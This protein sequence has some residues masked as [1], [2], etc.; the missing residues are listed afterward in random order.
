MRS[1][2]DNLKLIVT[3]SLRPL[4]AAHFRG[5]ANVA[6]READPLWQVGHAAFDAWRALVTP[7]DREGSVEARFGEVFHGRRS[8]EPW[9]KDRPQPAPV[10]AWWQDV[11]TRAQETLQSHALAENLPAPIAFTAYTVDTVGDAYDY[12]LYHTS[13]HAGLAQAA[14]RSRA[15]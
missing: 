5:V 7:F 9:G 11:L 2:A 10:F 6:P 8:Q 3:V 13:F 1:K 4:E 15:V 12:V 14:L